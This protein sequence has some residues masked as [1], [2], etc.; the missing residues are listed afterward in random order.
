MPL[1]TA[2]PQISYTQIKS[3]D[4]YLLVG[5]NGISLVTQ[6]FGIKLKTNRSLISSRHKNKSLLMLQRRCLKM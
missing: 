1:L 3:S 4:A 6:D 5:T 2:K